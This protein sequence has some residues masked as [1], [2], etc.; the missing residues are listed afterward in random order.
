MPCHCSDSTGMDQCL[1]LVGN[2]IE[3]DPVELDT[4]GR[5]FEPYRWHPCGVTW[6]AVPEQSWL[7]KLRRKPTSTAEASTTE[8]VFLTKQATSLGILQDIVQ[9]AVM[10]AAIEGQAKVWG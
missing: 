4:V 1:V 6:D 3:L 10:A 7:L 2:D 9:V 8:A 5:Q